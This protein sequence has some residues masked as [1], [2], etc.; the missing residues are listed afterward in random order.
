MSA[1]GPKTCMHSFRKTE[2]V[3]EKIHLPALYLSRRLGNWPLKDQCR[4][5]QIPLLNENLHPNPNH[6]NLKITGSNSV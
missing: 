4:G 1:S 6:V 2:D 3:I 5:K